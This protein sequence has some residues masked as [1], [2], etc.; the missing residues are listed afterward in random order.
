MKESS[1]QPTIIDNQEISRIIGLD[2]LDKFSETEEVLNIENT[3]ELILETVKTHKED[4]LPLLI[5]I[6]S[7]IDSTEKG[8]Q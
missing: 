4:L 7:E 8:I 5:D 2:Y 1:I 6:L 3:R